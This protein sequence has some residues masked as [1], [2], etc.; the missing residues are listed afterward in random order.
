MGG[1]T[2]EQSKESLD[3]KLGWE[4]WRKL[5]Y[6]PDCGDGVRAIEVLKILRE[7]LFYGESSDDDFLRIVNEGGSKLPR[8]IEYL[9]KRH[10]HQL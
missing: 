2:N 1:G 9:G 3:C 6:G 10:L 5:A 7:I 4:H 8:Y